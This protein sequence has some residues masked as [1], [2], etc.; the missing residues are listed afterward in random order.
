[1]TTKNLTEQ[2]KSFHPLHSALLG[3]AVFAATNNATLGAVAAVSSYVYMSNFGHGLPSM[4]DVETKP[5]TRPATA[6]PTATPVFHRIEFTNPY[7]SSDYSQHIKFEPGMGS[8][9]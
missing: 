2:I 5:N 8:V 1:M 6:Q 4:G 9:M 3:G 7:Q